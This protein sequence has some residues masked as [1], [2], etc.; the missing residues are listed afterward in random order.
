MFLAYSA[1]PCTETILYFAAFLWIFSKPIAYFFFRITTVYII[2]GVRKSANSI[3]VACVL[4]CLFVLI[5]PN[6]L[7][8]LFLFFFCSDHWCY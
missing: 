3:M 8:G 7:F 6:I 2:Q 1:I 4:F 5:A